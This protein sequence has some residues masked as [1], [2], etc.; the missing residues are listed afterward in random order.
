MCLQEY[1][2]KRL[3]Y[4]QPGFNILLPLSKLLHLQKF[5]QL[6]STSIVYIEK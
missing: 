2:H 1:N 3:Y 4:H 5:S 6:H